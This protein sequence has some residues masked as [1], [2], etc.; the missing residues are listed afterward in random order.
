MEAPTTIYGYMRKYGN[1]L[2][3][4]ILSTYKPLHSPSDPPSPLLDNLK[5]KLLPAQTIVVMAVAKYLRFANASKLVCECGAGKTI[6]ALAACYVHSGAKQHT[7]LVMAGPTLVEKWAREIFQTIPRAR[8][9]LVHD[10]RNGGDPRKPHGVTEVR[11]N[12]HKLVRNGWSGSL[13]DLRLMGRK[14]W[15]KICPEPAWFVMGK[16]RGKLSYFW[17]HCYQLAQSGSRKGALVNPDSG[18]RIV[19][20]EG[21]C[22]YSTDFRDAKRSQVIT[23]GSS[24]EDSKADGTQMF[25]ALWSA[26]RTKIQRMAPLD[27]VGRYLK[28]WWSYSIADE[29]HELNGDTAQGNGLAVLARAASKTVVLSGTATSGYADSIF[30]VLYRLDGPHMA[31]EGFAWGSQGQRQFQ[32]TYGTIEQVRKVYPQDNRCSRAPKANVVVRRRPGASPLLFGKFLMES[33]AFLSLE[34]IADTLPEYEEQVISLPMDA[35][36]ARGYEKLEKQIK[37]ALIQFPKAGSSITSLMLNSLLVYPDHPF[38]FKTLKALVRDEYGNMERVEIAEPE[39]LDENHLYPKEQWL[40]DDVRKERAEGRRVLVFATFTGAHDVT[41]RLEKVLSGAG[42]RVA[43]LRT[44]VP[45]DKREAW[46]TDRLREGVDVV[47]CHPRLVQTGLDLPQF[48]TIVFAETGYSLYTL[49]QASRRSWRIGQKKNV[50]VKFLHYQDTMQERCLRLMGKKMLVALAVE[51]KLSGEGL[52]TTSDDDA[53][54]ILTALAR[55][56][57]SEGGVGESADAVWAGLAR[58][59]NKMFSQGSVFNVEAEPVKP[60]T[61]VLRE[62]DLSADYA[63][64]ERLPDALPQETTIFTIDGEALLFPEALPTAQKSRK[65]K[66]PAQASSCGQMSLFTDLVGAA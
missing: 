48:P 37:D 44:S 59:R 46:F 61:Q 31:R 56:L 34:D 4:R 6:M 62:A 28:G 24:E 64:P 40:I 21:E 32:E 38:G 16:E 30:S 36:L 51:G 29:F 41:H 35:D 43:V 50:R 42:F 2:S 14:S 25:S 11:W 15:K 22:L 66:Q 19:N 23:R 47:V 9:F 39:N 17:R 58:E 20:S 54:D 57:V 52:Q 63:S 53:S 55:E 18:D 60:E 49:R 26:D 5:R 27:Y 65:A 33:T 1:L 10:M 8:V 13:T 7:G 12:G 45:T 3:E